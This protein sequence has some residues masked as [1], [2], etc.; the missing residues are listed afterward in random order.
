MKKRKILKKG[1]AY[2]LTI[3]MVAGLVTYAP[4]PMS[5]VQ[6]EET[7]TATGKTIAGLGTGV[8]ADPTAPTS[9][10]DA[11]QGSY[12]YFGT[13]NNSPVKYRVLDSNTS[14]FGGTTMLLDCDSILWAG[15][16]GDNQSSAFDDSSNVWADSDIRTYLNGTF[17]TNY[18]S[19]A[20]QN[21]IAESTKSAADSND[22]DGWSYLSY[23]SLSGDKIFFLDAKEATNTTY[24]YSNTD[25]SVTNRIKE[26][27]NAYWWL[28]SADALDDGN[29]GIVSS[30]GYIFSN[31]VFSNYVGVSPALNVNLSSV[32]FT[33]V[34]SGTAGETRAEYKL[35]LLDN[36]MSITAN[37]NPTRSGDTVSI[38]YTISGD[39][40]GNVSQVSI[41]L[42][43][44]AYTESDAQ[45]L[46]YGVL[47][48]SNDGTGT[49]TVPTD[50]SE[51]VCGTDYYAYIIA[52][53]VN[54]T[55]E[56]DYA[57]TPLSITIPEKPWEAPTVPTINIGTDNII[58]PAKP[59]SPY[60]VWKGCY[61]YYGIY[62]GSPVKYRVLDSETSVFGGTTML[63]DCD[64]ILW[65]G[66][67][68]D[69]QSS[70]FDDASNVWADSDIRAYLNGTFLNNYF[71]AA[72]Q[73]AIA[74]STK[75][76]E[77]SSDGNG[78][79]NLSYASL[80]GE[81]IFFLD[82]KEATNT[83]YGYSDIYSSATNRVKTGGNAYWWLR[84]AYTYYDFYAGFVFS[85]GNVYISGVDDGDV[86]V[87]PALN[88]NLSSV[89]FSS[90]SGASK[91]SALT[92]IGTTTGTEWKLTL[93]DT[94]KE[95]RITEN[96]KVVI[97]ANGNI[98]VPYTYTDTATE[99]A[100]KVNQ[101]SVMITDK[102]YAE[103]G[104]QILYYGSLDSI[105][106]TDGNDTTVSDTTTGTGTF[107]LPNTLTGTLGTDYH[108]Y[109]LAEH[110]NNDN[111]T[112][113]A[114][115][116]V[117]ITSICNEV[118]SVAITDIDTPSAGNAL[119]TTATVNANATA[120]VQ[121]YLGDE[122]VT[123]DA[124]FNKAYTVKIT[125]TAN[126]GYAF[127]NSTSVT[128]NGSAV[129]VTKNADGILTFSN[130]FDATSMGTIQYTSTGYEGT[131]D[132]QGHGITVE[133]TD[134]SDV[135]I[136]YSTDG[137]NYS[138]TNPTFT[139]ANIDENGNGVTVY[140]K[141]EKDDY[142]TITGSQT[143]KI[144]KREITIKAGDQS[145]TWGSD[146]S[147]ASNCAG[148]ITE[149]S[150]AEG[151]RL[152]FTLVPSTS[153]LTT[154]GIISV[155]NI[156]IQDDN[157]AD[158]IV[159]VTDNYS[160]TTVDGKLTI[161]HDTT[162]APTAISA[163]KT[164]TTYIAG[165]TLN[166]DDITVTATYAD[167]YSETVTGYTTNADSIDMNTDGDKTLMISYTANGGTVTTD[168]YITVMP[169]YSVTL[170]TTQTGYT[171]TASTDE[172]LWNGSVTFTFTLAEG[173]SKLSNFAVYV[174]GNEVALDDDG[175]YTVANVN[176]NLVVTVEG[177]ADVTAPTAEIK[178]KDNGWTEFLHTITFGLFFK[179]TQDV[180]I[181]ASDA[182][183]G[184][185]K[186]Y[187][188]IS[189]RD[190]E[191]DE[192]TK[193]NTNW[194]EYT[195][196][197]SIN[198]SNKYVIYAKIVDNASNTTYI[199]SEGIVVYTDSVV[200]TDSISTSYGAAGDTDVSVTLNGNTV[201]EIKCGDNVL[202]SAHYA[203][204]G[205]EGKITLYASYLNTL[206]AGMYTFTV[207]YNPLGITYEDGE[208]NDEPSA[209]VFTLT[210][211]RAGIAGAY[212]ELE[213]DF[214]YSGEEHKPV[215]SK[216]TVVL[217]G[218]TV[219]LTADD[220]EIKGY[221]SNINAGTATITIEGKGNYS[222]MATST[223]TI[224][225]AVISAI[226][227][228]MAKEGLTYTGMPQALVEGGSASEGT[229]VYSM[230]EDGEYTTAIPTRTDVGEYTVYYKV[231]GD[232][233]HL[234]TDPASVKVII[235]SAS[236]TAPVVGKTNETIAGKADGIIT[237]V[238]STMEYRKETDVD[239]T[240][241]TGSEI[242]G[243]SDGTYYVRYAAKT[244][245]EASADT[246]VVIEAGRMLNVTV[247]E[248][249]SGYTISVDKNE[250]VWNGSI[251]ISYTL[252]DGYSETEAFA[253]KV[254]GTEVTLA[255]GTYTVSDIQSD[256]TITVEGVAD[257]TAPT[258]EI[259]V[260]DNG[261][262]EFLHTITFG[263][264]FKE[265]QDVSITASDV[266]TGSG[267]D[268]IYYYISDEALS[269]AQVKEI[270]AWTEYTEKFS[271]TPDAKYVIYAKAVDNAGNITYVSSNGMLI[272]A[273]SPVISGV[274]DGVIYEGDVTFSV[275]DT[276][277]DKV[278]VD[279][280]EVELT[281]GSYTIPAD[282]AEHIIKATDIV[283][284]ETTVTI[285]V[286][287]GTFTVTDADYIGTYDGQ[288]HGITV[289]VTNVN[290]A[291]ITY[292][293]D[294]T[295]YSETNPAFTNVG[296][297]MV[298]YKVAKDRYTTVTGE[299]TVTINEKELSV[300]AD[301]QTII[302][303][304]C[305]DTG[306]FT[307]TGL[308]DGDTFSSVTLTPSTTEVTDNGTIDLSDAKIVNASGDDV[309]ANYN[310]TYVSGT[311]VI[312]ETA[313]IEYEITDGA[314]SE[315]TVNSDGNITITG[316]GDYAKFVGVKVDGAFIDE[317]NYTVKSG[318]TII[319]LKNSYL[320]TLSEGTHTFEIVW[321]DGT[322]GT[323]FTVEA[324]VDDDPIIPN[325]GDNT[326]IGLCLIFLIG[327]GL[328][329][330]GFW[331][332]RKYIV[333]E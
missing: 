261:W 282:N 277:L 80:G 144:A 223:F 148:N 21:S 152:T 286:N 58:S 208:N 273:T 312:V 281:D 128:L 31:S 125:L 231:I 255:N 156:K 241:V 179:E 333:E 113:Y 124:G 243:L 126:D 226:S 198:P 295:E 135:T 279:G 234:D 203:V 330:V 94:G 283:G 213:G 323:S 161:T 70:A 169:G 317:A 311:L 3:A 162:L 260:K 52:E 331:K 164:T 247:P 274:T 193:D 222:G 93:S 81:K 105:K 84:S 189:N 270:A 28:R 305:I 250:A 56:T 41:L 220:Y 66:T 245:Y 92:E 151:D 115:A 35:T 266:S 308:V 285:T 246:E 272:D 253:V 106:D 221:T 69:N 172:V 137:I 318:S 68:G 63:L 160:V 19:T 143:I 44:K 18:F 303:G 301:N 104:A 25:G 23:A 207:Y 26:G 157:T 167:G 75:S 177:V 36:G 258:V 111:A 37:G 22:G 103:D 248:N 54:G 129:T 262:T 43:D 49:F 229:V 210:V 315:W 199:S 297:Y 147:Q 326:P 13:Y 99:D 218:E 153:N 252:A 96:E 86:G 170:P 188:R 112:D 123:G 249:Q 269:E 268:K 38:P 184:I 118:S 202:D 14:V 117:E 211:E 46:H 299:A 67:N 212:M 191:W 302:V 217:G 138:E 180:T 146:I 227:M 205:V 88:L 182:G 195:G 53:E 267:V 225:K 89:L 310:I 192:V 232:A 51:K 109:I 256:I 201:K 288:A 171:L 73:N 263:L 60:D 289:D 119:D 293:M 154:E 214:T 209:T 284:N 134:P 230:T 6:A 190:L 97:D 139:D 219:E 259:K 294:G 332:K 7:T 45:I 10:S 186:I 48:T 292:S 275:I 276:Y 64:S 50:L 200:I 174:N 62:N 40:S 165:Q 204:D 324:A 233:N 30:D 224:E 194:V 168:V 17:L 2:L 77:D 178:V 15:T 328:T 8:I 120:S 319:T 239:Y 271:I 76:A 159:F 79:S 59:S 39:N 166:V 298:Y 325:T 82:A 235:S 181:T 176:E 71:S 296:T 304:E 55:Y 5:T 116:P 236:Q 34:I 85:D 121:W 290:D 228:P 16:N 309:T 100:E 321:T 95:I 122:E 196:K 65:A 102:E 78:Y 254:N 130:T 110:V 1:I 57:S 114:S 197:F 206:D 300:T 42:T 158:D 91:S 101:I 74:S 216:V 29:A 173:Y 98:I 306:K 322:A 9:T 20:E 87:S 83:T 185:D 327:S 257:V 90:A 244:N 329:A 12:V 107:T 142:T 287:Y 27:G 320:N 33:S 314:N 307:V 132:G 141:I 242:T 149:G 316:N 140:Y 238:D 251:T 133:V 175:T 145:I 278:Y 127:T 264:F 163:T 265:T 61:V 150:L 240:A 32:L 280:T 237:G 24:G 4:Y 187:Y 72:E 313:P 136:T 215:P 11:W 47:D 183:S 155:S 291:T 131:Y 108:V